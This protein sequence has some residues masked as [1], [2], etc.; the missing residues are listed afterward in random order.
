M[1]VFTLNETDYYIGFRGNKKDLN[2]GEEGD[3]ILERLAP[4]IVSCYLGIY[5]Y[6]MT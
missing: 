4:T 6:N 3:N 5:I 1:E 2:L